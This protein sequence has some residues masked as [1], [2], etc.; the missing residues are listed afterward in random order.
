MKGKKVILFF[1]LFFIISTNLSSLYNF[2]DFSGYSVNLTDKSYLKI[3]SYWNLTGSN[4][5]IDDLNPSYN[6]AYTESNYDWC[7]GSGTLNN[8]YIIE[9]VTINGQGSGTGIRILNSEKYFKI[10]NCTIF[11]ST[12]GILLSSVINGT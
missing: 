11:N 5:Y 12:T 1:S 10:K 7:S 8:P 3:A 2:L 6:W 4:I 9:N